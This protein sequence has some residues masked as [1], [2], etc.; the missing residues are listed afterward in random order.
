MKKM[1]RVGPSLDFYLGGGGGKGAWP[2]LPLDPP[3]PTPM[4][5]TNWQCQ[6]EV[7]QSVIMTVLLHLNHCNTEPAKA[8]LYPL[9]S[10]MLYFDH[11]TM[12]LEVIIIV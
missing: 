5:I 8:G 3:S 1:N 2:Q 9:H 4:V 11:I 12:W 7:K 10:Y 6:V